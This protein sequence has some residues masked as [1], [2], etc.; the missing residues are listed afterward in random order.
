MC[1][2]IYGVPDL[3]TCDGLGFWYGIN[4]LFGNDMSVILLFLI[5]FQA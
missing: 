2:K 5:R 4:I 1:L 3:M